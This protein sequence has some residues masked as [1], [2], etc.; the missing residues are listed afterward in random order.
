MS[1]TILF[2]SFIIKGGGAAFGGL[3]GQEIT[4]ERQLFIIVCV[5]LWTYISLICTLIYKM[6]LS[7]HLSAADYLS[8][9]GVN[10]Q[11]SLIGNTF[12]IIK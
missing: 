9:V 10:L 3:D 7:D 6:N 4:L 11:T 1:E 12:N 2:V 8:L 5:S